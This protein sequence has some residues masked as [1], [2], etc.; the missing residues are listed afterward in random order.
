MKASNALFFKKPVDFIFEFIP[1]L[2]LM[3]VLFGYMCTLIVVKWLTEYPDTAVAPS[4]IA[5]M[6]DMFLKMGAVTG[7]PLIGDVAFNTQLNQILLIIAACTVPLMLLV[8]P[9]YL[10]FTSE[11]AHVDGLVQLG[12]KKKGGYT[13]FED[14]ESAVHDQPPDQMVREDGHLDGE[15]SDRPLTLV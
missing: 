1:Q 6:I 8:K 7:E 12:A 11:P 10:K 2:T 5:F 3:L 14:E 4:I 9:F 13:Q 15:V